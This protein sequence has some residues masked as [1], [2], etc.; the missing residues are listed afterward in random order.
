MTVGYA[1]PAI[2]GP[3]YIC[4]GGTASYSDATP[5]YT[6]SASPGIISPTGVLTDTGASTIIFLRYGFDGSCYVNKTVFVEGHE[7]CQPC[8]ALTPSGYSLL[9]SST[10]GAGSYYMA[11]DLNITGNVTYTDA[12]IYVAPNAHIYVKPRASLTLK[13][14]HLFSCAS[15]MWNG[16]VL[17]SAGGY[18]GQVVLTSDASGNGNLIEDATVA[19]DAENLVALPSGLHSTN[20]VDCYNTVFNRNDTAPLPARLSD[21]RS[22]VKLTVQVG[23]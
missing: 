1:P 18:S 4:Y 2:T 13:G 6:W 3:D 16:I 19:I 23:Q 8:S 10:T 14:C 21:K 20:F 15:G 17:Q 5:G 9:T 22:A 7:G 11:S 12:V